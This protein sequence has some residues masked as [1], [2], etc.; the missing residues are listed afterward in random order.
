MY[1]YMYMYMYIYMY[2]YMYMYMYTYVYVYVYVHVYVYTHMNTCTHTHTTIYIYT[3]FKLRHTC[4][5]N[6]FYQFGGSRSSLDLLVPGATT[7]G[8]LFILVVV[9]VIFRVGRVPMK[10]ST[11]D[12]KWL[13]KCHDAVYP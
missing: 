1:M 10:M 7:R 4:L 8:K 3:L 11:R 5:N 13:R 6:I 9:L 12:G 2:M